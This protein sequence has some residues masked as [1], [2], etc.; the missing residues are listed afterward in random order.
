MNPNCSVESQ[1]SA[2]GNARESS[3]GILDDGAGRVSPGVTDPGIHGSAIPLKVTLLTNFIP[4]YLVPFYATLA[5]RT[6]ELNIL[7][8]TSTE[9]NRPWGYRG[10]GL[11]VTVQRTVALPQ[12]WRHPTGFVERFKMYFP[13]DTLLLLHRHKPDVVVSTEC[14]F[15]TLQSVLYC[16]LASGTRL[17]AWALVSELSERGRSSLRGALRRWILQR[18]D[19]VVVNGASGA[20]YIAALGFSP[21]ATFRMPYTT[22]AT[23]FH[24]IPLA[25]EGPAAHRLIYVG[26]LVE[27]KAVGPF[28]TVLAEWAQINPQRDVEFWIV[29]DG[30]LGASLK[31]IRLPENVSVRFLG[32]VPY[33]DL[34]S[35]YA[36][37]GVFVFPT[38]VDEWGVVVNE[39]LSA[40]L[41]IL[42]SLGSQAVQELVRD[43]ETG[44]TFSPGCTV[45]MRKAL[46]R[47]LRT[48]P[49]QLSQMRARC[50]ER[51]RD[52]TPE[53]SAEQMLKAI[54]FARGADRKAMARAR[55]SVTTTGKPECP[56][57][58]ASAA[59]QRRLP[60][61]NV[62]ECQN[63][64][65]RLRFAYPQLDP[66]QLE[67]A[68][69]T[70]YYPAAAGNGQGAYES[71]PMAIVE[72]IVESLF[73]RLECKPGSRILDYGCGVGTLCQ[74]AR[75]A[76]LE[77]TG[78]EQ[79]VHARESATG[80]GMRVYPH[81]EELRRQE[82]QA[83]FRAIIL[84]QVI[85]HLRAPWDELRKLAPLLD[86]RG[87]FIIAT[88]NSNCLQARLLGRRWA[89]YA[90]PTHFYYFSERSL[91]AALAGSGHEITD[92]WFVPRSYPHHGALRNAWQQ[93]L[94]WRK[95]NGELLFV[96]RLAQ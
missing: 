75:K 95:W 27:R 34:P 61:T 79:D 72:E 66:G 64:S 86:D 41:P 28:L 78:I 70:H 35:H 58:G 20:R 21:E 46:D 89:N 44:W 88:P 16:T 76:G 31:G 3:E 91:Q 80:A 32:N 93:F 59:F 57:C 65:C 11:P 24:A 29:G 87:R 23:A 48:P 15:R 47:A 6:K 40:G 39:A 8:S 53:S 18:A 30:P 73:N 85:E 69:R 74:A 26:Q 9:S 7:V 62:W 42:G 17:V 84:W 83:R 92:H 4:P 56:L 22:T 55:H 96:S 51:M 10:R 5:A 25:R 43:G 33:E 19:A 12:T 2:R 77:P 38:L 50:R 81:V 60:H 13:L 71:T 82:P 90:N 37:G 36:Q 94:R 52:I 1:R 14:G 54:Q 68:Y 49:D 45:E 63:S 67:V